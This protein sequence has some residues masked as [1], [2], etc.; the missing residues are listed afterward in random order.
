M[1]SESLKM[2]KTFLGKTVKVEIDRPL[3]SKHPK[4]GFVY[5]ANYGFVLNTKA[6]DG[7]DL[8]V[9]YLGIEKSIQK[10]EG[11]CIAIVH[12]KDDDDDNLVVVPE[13]IILSDEEI[14]RKVH[15]QEQWF[16]SE[17]VR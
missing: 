9:Y 13:G 1:E 14:M 10:S 6:P 12:R 3:G 5:E 17:I 4:H 11:V 15:F 16:D 2:A 8:D 7:E